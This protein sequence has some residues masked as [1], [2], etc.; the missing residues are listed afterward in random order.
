[1]GRQPLGRAET[2]NA[3]GGSARNGPAWIRAPLIQMA[4][5]WLRYQPDS[6]LSKCVAEALAGVKHADR[7]M[8]PASGTLRLQQAGSRDGS[9][10]P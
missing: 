5:R 2:R 8:G 1:M 9:G 3:T 6:A 10:A 4:W 7:E